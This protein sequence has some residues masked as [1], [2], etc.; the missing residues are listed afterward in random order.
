MVE[1]TIS[2]LLPQEHQAEITTNGFTAVRNSGKEGNRERSGLIVL[3]LLGR[4]KKGLH[5]RKG[6]RFSMGASPSTV[7]RK[8]KIPKK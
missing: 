4:S 7:G 2:E 8:K 5:L 6:K 3:P 1:T